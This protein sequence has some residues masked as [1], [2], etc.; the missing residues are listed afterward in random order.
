VWTESV[1]QDVVHELLEELPVEVSEPGALSDATPDAASIR[2]VDRL[3]VRAAQQRASDIHLEPMREGVRVRYRIDGVLR[4]V[5]H[6]PSAAFPSVVA[7]IKVIS[8]L[9]IADRRRPQDGRA[10]V[11]VDGRILDMRVSTLPSLFGEKAVIRLLPRS[12]ELPALDQ[13][14]MDNHQADLM[15]RTLLSPQGL[16]LITGPTGSGK[17]NTLYAAV[18]ATVDESRNVTTLEDPIEVELPGITQ[19]AV[20]EKAGLTFPVGLRSILRQDPDIVLVGEVRDLETA[21]QAVRA[22]LTG[23]LVLTTLHTLDAA[24]AITRLVDMGVPAYLVASS[25]SLVLSQR[26]V[27]RPCTECSV[28]EPIEP[29]VAGAV[30]AEPS[31]L[32]G[33]YMMRPVGCPVCHNS[34]YR[35]R[36]GLFEMLPVSRAVRRALLENGSEAA[37]RAA[38]RAEGVP[39]LAQAAAAAVVAGRTTLQEVLRAVPI[40]VPDDDGRLIPS[41]EDADTAT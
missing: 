27:R 30:G 40:E 12:E 37:V 2:L 8:H 9:D 36:V 41:A 15:R 25:L 32:A 21:E 6:M 29:A 17:T 38:A 39:P 7:R 3:I 26:L 5:L 13:L 34:G 20:N 16:V 28:P 35:G 10:R 14:G 22:S 33:R 1:Q 31:V 19:V 11:R 4:D 23:H 24:S 18:R